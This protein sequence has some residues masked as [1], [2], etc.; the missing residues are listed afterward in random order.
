LVTWMAIANE[1]APMAMMCAIIAITICICANEWPVVPFSREISDLLLPFYRCRTMLYSHDASRVFLWA[2]SSTVPRD[3]IEEQPF[4]VTLTSIQW[5]CTQPL[6][7]YFCTN[8]CPIALRASASR[9]KY[10]AAYSAP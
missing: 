4:A 2:A 6:C 8:Q 1:I 5:H 10:F 9:L 3:G 7:T